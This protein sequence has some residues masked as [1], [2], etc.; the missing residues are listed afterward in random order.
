MI[1][2]LGI[3]DLEPEEDTLGDKFW[4]NPLNGKSIKLPPTINLAIGIARVNHTF[5]YLMQG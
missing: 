5:K 2:L 4:K 1:Q 3:M